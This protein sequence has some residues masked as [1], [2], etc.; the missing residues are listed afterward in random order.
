[1]EN[2]RVFNRVNRHL[3]VT[4]R[5]KG[6][7]NPYEMTQTLDISRDGF[8]LNTTAP[9]KVGTVVEMF[10]QFPFRVGQRIALEGYVMSCS[11]VDSA[12]SGYRIGVR[13]NNLDNDLAADLA[14]FI[15][16][17]KER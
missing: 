12:K 3:I 9:L 10:V 5:K 6:Q 17:F 4:H 1:M 15:E 2:Q 7:D 13:I 8:A 16:K 11:K 14:I